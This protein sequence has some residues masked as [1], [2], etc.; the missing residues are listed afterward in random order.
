M[1]A[2]LLAKPPLTLTQNLKDSFPIVNYAG[3]SGIAVILCVALGL[4]L[5]ITSKMTHQGVSYLILGLLLLPAFWIISSA[6]YFHAVDFAPVSSWAKSTYNV[7]ISNQDAILDST[8][9]VD[10]KTGQ[11]MYAEKEYN[12]NGHLEWVLKSYIT[13][14]ELERSAHE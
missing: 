11:K 3:M 2:F 8:N 1:S 5:F 4:S 13:A 7:E 14:N 9:I 10:L 12:D 6:S